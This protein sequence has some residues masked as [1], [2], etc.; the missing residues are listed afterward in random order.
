MTL[1]DWI[2]NINRDRF[3]TIIIGILILSIGILYF[4]TMRNDH[5]WGGDFALYLSQAKSLVELNYWDYS[6]IS[7]SYGNFLEPWG[8]PLLLAPV[9]FLFGINVVMLK[10]ATS[11]FFI[12]SLIVIFLLFNKKISNAYLLL[13]I[14]VIGL[15]PNFFSFKEQILPDFPF[16]FSILLSIY[17][18][19]KVV[20]QRDPFVNYPVSYVIISFSIFSSFLIRYPGIILVLVLLLTEIISIL[21]AKNNGTPSDQL[22]PSY[23]CMVL[24][25]FI[26][27]ALFII[28]FYIFPVVSLLSRSSNMF[29][30]SMIANFQSYVIFIINTYIPGFFQFFV[31]NGNIQ[32]A[33]LIYAISLILFLIGIVILIKTDFLYVIFIA[34]YSAIIIS[35]TYFEYR[36]IF[37]IIPF[38]LYFC[39]IGLI[40]F[41]KQFTQKIGWKRDYLIS[42]S[43]LILLIILSV[44]GISYTYNNYTVHDFSQTNFGPDQKE[45]QEIFNYIETHTTSKD[46]V[47]FFKPSVMKL[48]SGRN[49][50]TVHDY[51]SIIN[52]DYK[53]FIDSETYDLYAQF[54]TDRSVID[55]M[56]MNHNDNFVIVFENK[57]FRIFEIRR[58]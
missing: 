34:C 57:N 1:I 42:I 26:F 5:D 19:Q 18:I 31:Y 38:Y 48:Y 46:A 53:Y 56:L 49:S 58:R 22:K 9:I 51:N 44:S 40:W 47:I 8:Y 43:V 16:L 28:H 6:G 36:Y 45:N 14:L 33:I 32:T 21:I 25:Y 13:L 54:G 27:V 37:P 52:G 4:L 10:I 55:A 24:P 11:L 23:A 7:R 39:L 15:N 29:N 20:V 35:Y 30:V 17:L 3:L 2:K 41:S 12:L 50:T